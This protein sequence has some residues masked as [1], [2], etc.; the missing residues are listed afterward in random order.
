MNKI[1]TGDDVMVLAGRDKGQ[2][3]SVVKVLD[4]GRLIVQGVNMVK[5]HTKPNPMQNQPGGIVEKE[6]PIDVSN[7][8]LFNPVTGRADRVGFRTL[9][10]GRKVRYFKSNGEILDL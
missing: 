7:V 5:R 6:A 10:D 8:G 1:R 4:D 3:G 9:D 2:R